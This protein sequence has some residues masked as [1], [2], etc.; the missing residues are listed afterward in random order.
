MPV[1]AP[2]IENAVDSSLTPQAASSWVPKR[3]LAPLSQFGG[4]ASSL[5]VRVLIGRPATIKARAP[6]PTQ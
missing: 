4:S 1:A 2:C 6:S 5:S 3:T